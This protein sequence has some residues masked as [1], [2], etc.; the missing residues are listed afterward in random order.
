MMT[1]PL[2][3]GAALVVIDPG[4]MKRLKEGRPLKL[5]KMLIAYT[6]DMSGFAKR[7]GLPKELPSKG[8]TIEHRVRLTPEQIEDALKACKDLPEVEQ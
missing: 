8:E 3:D 1:F 4:N 7:L 5:G 6:P 2:K